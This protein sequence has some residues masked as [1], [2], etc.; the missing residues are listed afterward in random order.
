MHSDDRD[1]RMPAGRHL[2]GVGSFTMVMTLIRWTLVTVGAA[3]Y[4]GL[5]ILGWGG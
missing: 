4:L 2:T 3:A 1:R 5:A